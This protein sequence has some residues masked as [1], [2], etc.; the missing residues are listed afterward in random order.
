MAERILQL[1]PTPVLLSDVENAATLNREL[2]AAILQE[3]ERDEG[4]KLSNRGGWQSKRDFDR[5]SGDAGRQVVRAALDLA[6]AHT[7]RGPQSL[8]QGW[9]VDAWA[10]VNRAG[11]FNMPHVH[12]GSFW[13]AVYYVSTGER[14]GG[15]LVLHDPRMPALIMHSPGLHFRDCGSEGMA[16]IRPS[17]GL[18]VLFPAWLSHSVEPWGGS[19]VRISV[20]MNIRAAMA[21]P[22]TAR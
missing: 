21:P 18:L 4:M 7:V 10:N 17:A 1:F 16:R 12:G 19:G 2:E 3:A 9:S 22:P 6:N 13:S 8:H 20:A 5:I 15:D 14:D 11:D